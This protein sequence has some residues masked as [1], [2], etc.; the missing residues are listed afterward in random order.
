MNRN[1][2]LY[3]AQRASEY[4]RIYARSERQA[5]LGQLKTYLSV[6]FKG[7]DVLEIACGTGYWTQYAAESAHSILATDINADMLQIAASRDYPKCPVT[8]RLGDAFNLRDVPSGHD[9]GLAGFF[10]SHVPM[11]RRNELINTFHSRLKEYSPVIWLDN[12]YQEGSS[13]PTSRQDTAAQHLSNPSRYRMDHCTKSLKTF[14]RK[15]SYDRISRLLP[16]ISRFS[17]F[18]TTGY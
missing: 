16:T 3:Y 7:L 11:T 4:D 9:A 12:R 13:T 6:C 5:D 15:K 14:L 18:N 17:I 1:M 10:W 2:Q 8:F